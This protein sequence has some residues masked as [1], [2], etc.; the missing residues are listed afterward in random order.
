MKTPPDED[1]V[2]Q[3][4]RSEHNI[5]LHEALRYQ[6]T[7]HFG[8]DTLDTSI[9]LTKA[10]ISLLNYS[11]DSNKIYPDMILNLTPPVSIWGDEVSPTLEKAPLIGSPTF[12]G[13]PLNPQPDINLTSKYFFQWLLS[14]RAQSKPFLLYHWHHCSEVNP[15]LVWP[16]DLLWGPSHVFMHNVFKYLIVRTHQEY[17]SDFLWNGV[18]GSSNL[19][20]FTWNTIRLLFPVTRFH[21]KFTP[22]YDPLLNL[23]G[24]TRLLILTIVYLLLTWPPGP[25]SVPNTGW[26]CFTPI[27]EAK[28]TLGTS[29][30]YL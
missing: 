3:F 1:K 23:W 29:P 18:T 14:P 22:L 13:S 7:T 16:H 28:G 2:H 17:V 8:R 24:T 6:G 26:G 4:P 11:L 5:N 30:M 21:L 20:N 15:T 25:P 9:L 19:T 10:L 27:S 12:N